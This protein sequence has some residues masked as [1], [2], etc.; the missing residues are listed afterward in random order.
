MVQPL[1]KRMKKFITNDTFN[2][3]KQFTT[4]K[5]IIRILW[6]FSYIISISSFS[7][8]V[9]G[10]FVKWQIDPDVSINIRTLSYHDIP[11]PAVTYCSPY[12]ISDEA[13]NFTDFRMKIY[14]G[15]KLPDYSDNEQNLLST[16]L[17]I[18]S[19]NLRE[20]GKKIKEP[21]RTKHN[22]VNQQ[23]SQLA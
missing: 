23:N 13:V 4:E 6:I 3:L 22:K 16:M 7:Y 12:V 1:R 5:W 11:F 18:C 21:N 19:A 17:E 10:I 2:I 8:Y 9:Y 20:N 14:L 15:E